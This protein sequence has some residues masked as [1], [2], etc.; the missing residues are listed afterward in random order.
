MISTSK[1]EPKEPKNKGNS[2]WKQLLSGYFLFSKETVR[3]Y[4]YIAYLFLLLI[5]TVLYEHH[6]D[7]KRQYIKYLENE[8]KINISELKHNNQYIPYEENQQ[9]KKILNAKG[10]ENRNNQVYR[11]TVKNTNNN[12]E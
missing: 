11:I 2:I 12:A 3:W 7:S 4:P 10:F 5:L 1:P 6:M 8:Y 9:L